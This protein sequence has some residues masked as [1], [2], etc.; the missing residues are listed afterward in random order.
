[1]LLTVYIL[2]SPGFDKVYIGFTSNL[3]TRLRAHNFLAAKGYTI[4]YRP[5][6]LI[7]TETFKTKREA[8]TREKELKSGK[9]RDF[10]R[11]VLLEK[12]K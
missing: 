2:Y 5:W 3:E 7:H 6:I 10:I 8:M 11:R 12:S 9:G 1:M 4:R